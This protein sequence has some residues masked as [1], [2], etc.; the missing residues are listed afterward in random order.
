[1]LRDA[2]K[3]DGNFSTRGIRLGKRISK[4]FMTDESVSVEV[5]QKASSLYQCV[6]DRTEREADDENDG[7][8]SAVK[9]F[10]D[11]FAK[12]PEKSHAEQLAEKNADWNVPKYNRWL[13]LD[14]PAQWIYYKTLDDLP[15][16]GIPPDPRFVL[17]GHPLDT[18]KLFVD[19][20][21]FYVE[22]N[23]LWCWHQVSN[24][25]YLTALNGHK[26]NWSCVAIS[27]IDE[28]GRIVGNTDGKQH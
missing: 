27:S 28:N 21:L 9:L 19:G 15:L 14:L 20:A 4:L 13:G 18:F 5:R 16:Y 1:L 26:V 24:P 10:V 22:F 23:F 7:T 8:N 17:G 2:L 12:R 11:A 3:K 25:L 6:I